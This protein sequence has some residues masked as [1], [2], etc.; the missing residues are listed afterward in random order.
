MRPTFPLNLRLLVPVKRTIDYAV[1]VVL[2]LLLRS[3]LSLKR[4]HYA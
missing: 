2:L 1:S 3:A 4:W